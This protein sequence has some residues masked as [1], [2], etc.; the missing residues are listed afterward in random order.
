LEEGA[1]FTNAGTFAGTI[2]TDGGNVFGTDSAV[3]TM[4]TKEANGYA[5]TKPYIVRLNFA[6][7]MECDDYTWHFGTTEDGAT[8]GSIIWYRKDSVSANQTITQEP[9]SDTISVAGT[10]YN[11]T[12]ETAMVKYVMVAMY[13]SENKL[14][15]IALEKV[16]VI[17]SGGTYTYTIEMPAD[18]EASAFLAFIVGEGFVPLSPAV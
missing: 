14:L 15:D 5:L 6:L 9:G 7:I 10:L 2:V 11:T 17:E 8:G 1:A 18:A 16:G 13:S 4:E 12:G 3:W